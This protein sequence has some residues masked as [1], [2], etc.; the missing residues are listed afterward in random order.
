MCVSERPIAPDD[1]FVRLAS[2]LAAQGV[3]VPRVLVVVADAGVLFLEDLGD[4]RLVD[5]LPRATAAER[6][7]LYRAAVD[8]V[9]HLQRRAFPTAGNPAAGRAFD[10]DKYTFEMNDFVD[11]YLVR[12][13]GLD[14][15]ARRAALDAAL[16]RVS[17]ELAALP[18]V[19]V[20]RD[21]HARN[22]MVTDGRL[23]VIDFQDARM[24]PAEYDLAS[25]LRDSYVTLGDDEREGLLDHYARRMDRTAA[26]GGFRRRFEWSALQRNLK[27]IGTFARLA[28]T[29]GLTGYLE[30][31]P[32]TLAYVR[33]ALREDGS[34]AFVAE[35]LLPIL[36]GDAP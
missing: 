14:L 26:D 29:R 35:A 30:S 32:P 19:F 2:L 1:D 10:V 34:L 8:I 12:H 36:E 22:L 11:S 17:A 25:L 13:R 9:V 18:R 20:H 4:E 16:G 7:D 5:R 3:A 23:R 21:Y 27:A 24:G 15:G 6:A 31:I 33:R 28:A